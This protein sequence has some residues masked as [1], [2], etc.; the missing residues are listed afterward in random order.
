MGDI[1]E[2]APNRDYYSL[3]TYENH[4]YAT[5]NIFSKKINLN[6]GVNK[7]Y[8]LAQKIEAKDMPSN[9][10]LEKKDNYYIGSLGDIDEFE[11]LGFKFVKQ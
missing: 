6:Q 3:G 11:F 4:E 5:L 8:I 10:T 2:V 7:I 9:L 1:F